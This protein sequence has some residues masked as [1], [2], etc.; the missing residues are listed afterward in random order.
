MKRELVLARYICRR[1]KQDYPQGLPSTAEFLHGVPDHKLAQYVNEYHRKFTELLKE[2]YSGHDA[3]VVIA[4]A[5]VPLFHKPWAIIDD[6]T[7]T[8]EQVPFDIEGEDIAL[9]YGWDTEELGSPRMGRKAAT[10]VI[11][12]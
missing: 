10:I 7:I 1:Q 8:P 12:S 4:E 11:E 9:R 3:T 6:K 2:G 5:R